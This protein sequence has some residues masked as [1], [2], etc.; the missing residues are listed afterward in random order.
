MTPYD[1]QAKGS[2]IFLGKLEILLSQEI[3]NLKTRL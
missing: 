1:L 2:E 3:Y